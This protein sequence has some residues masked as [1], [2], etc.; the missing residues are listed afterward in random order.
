MW[1]WYV[2]PLYVCVFL[3]VHSGVTL[4]CLRPHLRILYH[5][6]MLWLLAAH[7]SQL[8]HRLHRAVSTFVVELDVDPGCSDWARVFSRSPP[9]VVRVS[10]MRCSCVLSHGVN[11]ISF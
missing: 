4:E 7:S 11:Q 9:L 3:R 8:R 5:A 6:L 2:E 1:S 10:Y